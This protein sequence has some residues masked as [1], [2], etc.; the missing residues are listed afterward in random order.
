MFNENYAFFSGTSEFMG[1]HFKKFAD[2]VL[3][4][5]IKDKKDPFVVEI[6]RRTSF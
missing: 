1:N 5:Y 3:D 2:H 4:D 6:G